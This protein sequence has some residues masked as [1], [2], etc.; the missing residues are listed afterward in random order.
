MDFGFD[1]S[2][3]LL[4][5]DAFKSVFDCPIKKIHSTHFLLFV[6][7][8]SQNKP[9]LGL[10][11]TKKKIKKAC[12]RN[13]IKRY[14]REHFRLYQHYLPFVDCVLIVK[15]TPKKDYDNKHLSQEIKELFVVLSQFQPK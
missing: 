2:K 7:K 14:S 12:D 3:R 8:S 10:A 15:K 5:A 11:I 6:A 4:N 1:K 9:R 13:R